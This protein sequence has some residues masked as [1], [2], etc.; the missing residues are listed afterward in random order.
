MEN[1]TRELD[2]YL[3][4]AEGKTVG[5]FATEIANILRGKNKPT[6]L[7]NVDDGDY[8][9][10]INA[11]KIAFTG[12]KEEQ[13]RYYHHT[14][15]LGNLKTYTVADIRKSHPEELIKHAVIGMLPQNKLSKSFSARLKIYTGTEHP[16]QNIKFKNA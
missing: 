8:V 7:P 16:H 12:N 14:G 3:L 10:V 4:D 6:F 13:K 5:R 11:D 1:K 2:W 9:V 15:Y